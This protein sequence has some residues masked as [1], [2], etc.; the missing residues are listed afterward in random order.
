MYS[1]ID[2]MP[3]L[4]MLMLTFCSGV[5][6]AT[7]TALNATKKHIINSRTR[8]FFRGKSRTDIFLAPNLPLAKPCDRGATL[9]V[10]RFLTWQVYFI[11]LRSP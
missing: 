8:I 6:A 7:F 4:D 11:W 3:V 2:G 1:W 5:C 9:Q 10:Y